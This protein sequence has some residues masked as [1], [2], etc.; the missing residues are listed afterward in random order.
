MTLNVVLLDGAL[1][2]SET[3]STTLLVVLQDG[4]IFFS[5]TFNIMVVVVLLDRALFSMEHSALQDPYGSP[6]G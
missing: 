3:F 5:V 2:F 1:F 4:I 6:T